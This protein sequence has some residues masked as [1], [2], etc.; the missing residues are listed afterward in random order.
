MTPAPRPQPG[1]PAPAPGLRQRLETLGRGLFPGVSTALL[2]ILAA[3]PVGIPAA[4]EAV[5]LPCIF[6]WTV[7]RPGSMSAPAVF[8][9]GL[10]QDL[11]TMAPFGTGVLVL[12]LL[13]AVALRFRL[14]IARQSFLIVWLVFCAHALG[15]TL[16]DWV[17]YGVLSL[18]LAPL[19]PALHLCLMAA[20]LYPALALVLSRLHAAMQEAEA[21]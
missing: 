13:H 12:L 6:F 16:L 2:M 20:G 15:A 14:A 1:R 4:V 5:T 17:L 10:L 19:P 21:S 11:L 8:L 3:A 7:F 18:R 9:L